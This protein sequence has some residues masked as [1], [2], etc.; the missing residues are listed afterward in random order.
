MTIV[1]K[2][3][4]GFA[5]AIVLTLSLG[6]AGEPERKVQATKT[7]SKDLVVHEWGTF[8]T[9]SGSDGKNLKF[10]PYDNDLPEFVHG[11]K[12]ARSKE[13]PRGGLISLETPVVYFYSDKP[14]KAS[15]HVDFPKGVLTEWY[16]DAARTDNNLEWKGIEV[17]PGEKL[18]LLNEKRESRYY[19]ARETDSCPLRVTFY[20]EG[21][22]HVENEQL[23]FYRGV[24]D[25]VMP[26]AVQ[27]HG[28]GKFTVNWRGPQLAE[29]CLL[30]QV[31]AGKI[32]FQPFKMSELAK[33]SYRA[34]V[35]ISSQDSSEEKLSATLVQR[36]TK[37][38]LYEKEAKAMVKTWKSAW[39]GE[40]GTRVL[41]FLPGEMT[42][43]LLPLRVEPKP[44][45]V[46]R[47][48][49]GRHDVLTPEGEKQID[50][51]VTTFNRPGE[52]KTPAQ[53][54]AWQELC[55][56]GRYRDAV[57]TQAEARLEH[58]R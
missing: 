23:L 55:K 50:K 3:A 46:L 42:E 38:G 17:L 29:E 47:V 34:D 26:L 31:K 21:G 2:S 39:F 57:L 20:K 58:R 1:S 22:T 40:E 25:F 30:I 14:L 13:G 18:R 41:Y 37:L 35:Q 19:A 27:A 10:Y 49:V 54:A 36:L 11:Y 16:P 6:V 4:L 33:S 44:K 45:T 53:Q 52:E 43:E 51:L 32:R 9:F 12:D 5:V 7:L 48:L 56:L 28:E 8:S 15:V 24:G